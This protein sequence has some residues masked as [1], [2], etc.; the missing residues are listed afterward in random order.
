MIQ[1][2][3]TYKWFVSPLAILLL[4]ELSVYFNLVSEVFPAPSEVILR[5]KFLITKDFG[6]LLHI[7]DSLKRLAI[8][9]LLAIPLAILLAISVEFNRVLAFIARPVIAIIYPLPKLAIFPLLIIILGSGELA[10]IGIIFI[11]V[12]FAVH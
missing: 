3:K 9:S 7:L 5:I 4:W 12:F 1:L 6:F 2:D 8:G 11:G 10:Q